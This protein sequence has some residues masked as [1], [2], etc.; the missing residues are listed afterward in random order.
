MAQDNAQ[1]QQVDQELQFK[2]RARRR[3]VGAVALVLI[4][5]TVLPMVLD[6]HS[7]KLPQPEI[8]I[9]IP[10]Q[11]E[12]VANV[13]P[14]NKAASEAANIEEVPTQAAPMQDAPMLDKPVE[15]TPSVQ[16]AKVETPV[17]ETPKPEPV[18]APVH[19]T[20]KPE[21]SAD[22]SKEN[23]A[24]AVKAEAPTSKKAPAEK[25]E[26]VKQASVDKASA[27]PASKTNSEKST[28][29]KANNDKPATEVN[30]TS[31]VQIGVFSDEANVKQLQQQLKD[32]G[33]K[34]F[35]EKLDTPKGVKLRLRAGP[36]A[37]RSDA[38]SA[39]DKI[40]SLG[41]AGMVVSK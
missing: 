2:K 7:K 39:L 33:F 9:T 41:L 12:V 8:S 19:S 32:A 31:Y 35:T 14:D 36:F 23:K 15:P 10:S 20:E 40:K 34:S 30:H 37:S 16:P 24:V 26:P 3:L 6:D 25:A 27:E 13:K 21:K 22:K 18:A 38:A 29:D 1:S 11:D 28:A 17:V 4:M 5:V